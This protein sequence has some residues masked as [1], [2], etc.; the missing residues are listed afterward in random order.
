MTI[1][2]KLIVLTA[3]SLLI[4][5]VIIGVIS[6][7]QLNKTGKMSVAHITQMGNEEI[8]R[9]EADGKKELETYRNDLLAR[10]K[11]YLKSQ[12]Q[13][14][15]GVLEKGYKDSHSFDSIKAVYEDQLRNAV[16]TAYSVLVAVE[17]EHGLSFSEKQNKAMALV[18]TLRYGPENKDYF[19]I[20]DMRSIMVMHPFSPKLDGQDLSNL[21][22]S[23]GKKIFTEFV[24]ECEKNGQ[25][26]VD[27]LWPKPGFEEPQPKLSYVKLFEPWGWVIGSGVYLEV[28]EERLK[29]ESAGVI[30]AL[31]FGPENKDYFWI[32]DLHPRMVMHPYK[33]ELNGKDL[34]GSKDPNGKKPFAEMADIQTGKNK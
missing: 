22:D 34:T 25:G 7:V 24:K 11:E 21:K 9:I 1:K 5:A 29:K 18:K 16:N 6:V 31:R 2:T 13:T 17:S 19:W 4:T 30:E 3:V 27:Y 10:K 20:N 32:N 14:A 8:H 26:F 28:A 12:I 33:P 15:V 23:N